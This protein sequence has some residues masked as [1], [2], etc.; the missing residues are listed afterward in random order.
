M[1]DN[2]GRN[3]D[4]GSKFK[5]RLVTVSKIK[6]HRDNKDKRNMS[7]FPFYFK[8]IKIHFKI[9]LEIYLFYIFVFIS[10]SKHISIIF[11]FT[12]FYLEILTNHILKQFLFNL[13]MHY[14][15]EEISFIEIWLKNFG[16]GVLDSREKTNKLVTIKR[17]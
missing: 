4:Q 11:I 5:L 1:V 8:K 10:S 13:N 14:F 12:F 16:C 15:F 9:I 3:L 17:L 2:P 6:N 7:P